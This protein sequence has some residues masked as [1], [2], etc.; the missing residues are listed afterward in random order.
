MYET[1]LRFRQKSQKRYQCCSCFSYQVLFTL[2]SSFEMK[3]NLFGAS[4]S[5]S[6]FLGKK[7]LINLS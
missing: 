6:A 2:Y 4:S 3:T 1:Q 5:F 7:T